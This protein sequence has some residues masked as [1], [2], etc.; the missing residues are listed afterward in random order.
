MLFTYYIEPPV[1]PKIIDISANQ[2]IHEGMRVTFSCKATGQ[3]SP[4]I[5]WKRFLKSG[6][7]NT[8]QLELPSPQSIRISSVS[9]RDA[10]K[11]LC[12]AENESGNDTRAVYLN[13]LGK[14]KQFKYTT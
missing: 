4:Q 6:D 9:P 8:P 12:I 5:T 2:T 13:V 3:P 11:Y 7:D 1:K 10:G 14:C